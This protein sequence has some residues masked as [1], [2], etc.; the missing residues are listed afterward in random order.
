MKRQM[1]ERAAETCA[2]YATQVSTY[3]LFVHAEGQ[4]A[5]EGDTKEP[6]EEPVGAEG[7]KEEAGE[8]NK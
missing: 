7:V 8:A 5:E 3:T 4:Q 1:R 2:I 6:E